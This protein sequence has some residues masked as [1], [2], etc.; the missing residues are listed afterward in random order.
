M[1]AITAGDHM[2]TRRRSFSAILGPSAVLLALSL[3]AAV[4]AFGGAADTGPTTTGASAMISPAT[5]RH[6]APAVVTIP[7]AAPPATG[8]FLS[9]SVTPTEV[10]REETFVVG[11]FDAAAGKDAP[12]LATFAF[13]PPMVL[14]RATSFVAPLAHAPTVSAETGDARLRIALVPVEGGEPPLHTALTVTDL[15]LTTE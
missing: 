10:R 12:A 9:L 11:V 15:R 3:P 2:M 7:A 5:V 1:G 6:D 13:Y 8:R 4:P 14:G